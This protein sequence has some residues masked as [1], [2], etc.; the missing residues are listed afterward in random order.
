LLAEPGRCN[1]VDMVIIVTAVI[2]SVRDIPIVEVL[3]VIPQLFVRIYS[4][5]NIVYLLPH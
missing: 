4:Y 2:A 5:P 1:D 3:I